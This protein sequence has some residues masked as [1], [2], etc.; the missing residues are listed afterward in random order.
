MRAPNPMGHTGDTHGEASHSEAS[1]SEGGV[2]KT[3]LISDLVDSTALVEQLG[4]ARASEL[5]RSH[6]RL[7]RD[8][9]A[10]HRGLEVDKSDG[11]LLLFERP[12]E[13]VLF[14]LSYHRGLK[15]LAAALDVKLFARV[16][17]HLGEVHLIRNAPSD[18]ARGAKPVEVEGLAKPF[19][20]RLM[21]VARG[22]QTLMSRGAFDLARRSS[23]GE[24]T[25][26]DLKWLAHGHYKLK[27]V[28][29]PVE[30]FEVGVDGEAPLRA[31]T[32]G[33]KVKRLSTASGSADEACEAAPPTA[34]AIGS[35]FGGF[36]ILSRLGAGGM[37]VVYEARDEALQRTVALKVLP[38]AIT[39]DPGRRARFLREA[40]SAAAVSHPSVATIYQV[41]TDAGRVYIAMELIRGISLR[42]ALAQGPLPFDKAIRIA[43][44]VTRGVACAHAAG[45]IHRDLKP[46]N[47]MLSDDGR[48]KVLDF[49]LAKQ[50]SLTASGLDG[51][52]PGEQSVDGR[53]AGTPGYMSPEQAR[54]L[55]VDA[56]TD[57]YATGVLIYELLSGRLPFEGETPMDLLIAA[58][59]DA[60]VPLDVSDA[61][62]SVLAVVDR[63]L[64][65]DASQRYAD[66]A[67]LLEDLESLVGVRTADDEPVF[68]GIGAA[69][70]PAPGS[71]TRS[72]S[73]ISARQSSDAAVLPAQ[74]E[75]RKRV[76][77]WIAAVVALGAV[78][79]AAGVVQWRKAAH[80][81]QS[82]KLPSPLAAPGAVLAC[83]PLEA[84]G[85]DEPTGWL[86]AVAADIACRRAT[87]Y[88]GGQAARTL[89]P[90]QLLDAPAE[91]VESLV[92]DLFDRADARPRAVEAAKHRA[93][94]WLDGSIERRKGGF[95]VT[96]VLRDSDGR[97][98]GRGAG[99]GKYVHEAVRGAMD[100]MVADGAI[101]V[102]AALDAAEAPWDN[103]TDPATRVALFDLGLSST[104]NLGIP[105]V[106]ECDRV[107]RVS[108]SIHHYAPV[109]AYCDEAR[110]GG[111][112]GV[113]PFPVDR[114][115]PAAFALTAPLAVRYDPK[116]D[117]KALSEEAQKLLD[118]AQGT[119]ERTELLLA[120]VNLNPNWETAR[121]A[122]F[123]LVQ[124]DPRHFWSW[125]AACG[126]SMRQ[127][128]GEIAA[129]GLQ[130]WTPEQPEAWNTG[131][132]ANPADDAETRIRYGRRAVVLSPDYPVFASNL[133]GYLITAGRLE[134]VRTLAAR[135]ASGGPRQRLGAES[136]LVAVEQNEGRL[137][138]ALERAR[139]ALAEVP[140]ISRLENC[141]FP[142]VEDA[143]RIATILGR[144]QEVAD[145]L[146]ERFVL[147]EPP[148]LYA[149]QNYS[150]YLAGVICLHASR[151][152][153]ARCVSRLR[154]LDRA[155]F[156]KAGHTASV[157]DL[158]E[159]LER[160][161]AGDRAG[162]SRLWRPL[163]TTLRAREV[164]AQIL[165]E[166]GDHDQAERI[167]RE[168]I[169]RQ[170]DLV[171]GASLAYV[172]MAERAAKRGD[173]ETARRL[174][175]KVIEAWGAADA[176]VPSV[177][178]MKKL[179]D[180]VSTAPHP[181]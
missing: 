104:L 39:D 126:L 106:S 164:R 140:V 47:V 66:A 132:F 79:I 146:A 177:G 52:P 63:C 8:L 25:S 112:E 175:T 139:R 181:H 22:G 6:D 123:D 28:A 125:Q 147:A 37:G 150:T 42:Q 59:R 10:E 98:R 81:G 169:D 133:A 36:H 20:A 163:G 30:L 76:A 97:E 116:L 57:V 88:S 174:A 114:S 157:L 153:S 131:S 121:L 102:A 18:V 62:P 176:E 151:S 87:I 118:R 127:K 101:P 168:S 32:D 124:R 119:R 13:A 128:G 86:G 154:Q 75:R 51:A 73:A 77:W 142:L 179:L 40:R 171:N 46:D 48:V 9:L 26:A 159:G 138:A 1:H 152:V 92:A 71:A 94:A 38:A 68:H 166:M 135:L 41:G 3:L 2:L 16:G 158:L 122:V 84:S 11:F 141:D 14:A 33:E 60:Y 107:A 129:R 44:A 23:V 7:A 115:T 69:G 172:R 144:G 109:E 50:V 161:H 100:P 4:D 49:G 160:Y 165:D 35:R 83:P 74:P 53:I 130:T 111:P 34:D 56:R 178:Q 173:K 96:L 134:E 180:R 61:P 12:F 21:S 149:Y 15:Q 143:L 64:A 5:F 67:A 148:R 145:P 31:P 99:E 156:F 136:L 105:E 167:D 103:T 58:S 85:V 95:A 70:N 155:G 113:A 110:R 162:V 80:D 78:G 117:P 45:V 54:G 93:Q 19:T 90:A 17:I 27:G 24:P 89:I 137:F 72:R 29:E 82:G 65:K 120:R 55:P 170:L 91:V 108:K 43:I